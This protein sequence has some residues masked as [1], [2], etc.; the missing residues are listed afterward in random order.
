MMAATA[1]ISSRKTTTL[2]MMTTLR[3]EEAAEGEEKRAEFPP[4]PVGDVLSVEAGGRVVELLLKVIRLV[5]GHRF[6]GLGV[7]RGCPPPG[8]AENDGGQ[9][10]KQNQEDD[11]AGDD[12]HLE[13][14]GRLLKERKSGQ[15]FRRCDCPSAQAQA[16][17]FQ[18]VI[19]LSVEAGGRVVELLL[20]VLRLVDGY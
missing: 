18:S 9:N 12:D 13:E 20:K 6:L 1:K 19:F 8:T 5:D 17:R 15:N 10:E 14:R 11:H 7:F 3:R 2:A 4:V 16:A